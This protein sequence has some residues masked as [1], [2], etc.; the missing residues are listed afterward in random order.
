MPKYSFA[1][2][3]RSAHHLKEVYRHGGRSDPLRRTVQAWQSEAK[4]LDGS[5]VLKIVFCAVF[6]V[7]MSAL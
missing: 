7:E 3:L 1:P 5:E 4:R 6:H 2:K